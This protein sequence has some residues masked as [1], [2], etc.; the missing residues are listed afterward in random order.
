MQIFIKSERTIA[1][2][3]EQ[4]CTVLELKQEIMQKLG[5]PVSLQRLVYAGKM[6]ENKKTLKDYDITKEATIYLSHRMKGGERMRI[7]VSCMLD[8]LR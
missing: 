2:D 4:T 5:W 3:V 7:Y 6:L 8:D 1:Y